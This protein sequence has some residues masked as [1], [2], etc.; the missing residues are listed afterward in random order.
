MLQSPVNPHHF[1]WLSDGRQFEDGFLK[2]GVWGQMVCILDILFCQC[3]GFNCSFICLMVWFLLGIFNSVF[4]QWPICSSACGNNGAW[5]CAWACICNSLCIL[6]GDLQEKVVGCGV[7]LGE[8]W[9]DSQSSVGDDPVM[10]R[11]TTKC[12]YIHT[13][14]SGQQSLGAVSHSDKIRQCS[15]HCVNRD[16]I[17][18]NKWR[19]SKTTQ[20][21]A[22]VAER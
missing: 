21:E 19:D 17:K 6:C 14:T 13:A 12:Y 4:I 18:I 7:D 16:N 5:V 22:Q 1:W 10:C 9:K 11:L 2:A 20:R 15:T 8:V 3:V